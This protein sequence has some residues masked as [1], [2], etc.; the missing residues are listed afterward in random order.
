MLRDN[1]NQHYPIWGSYCPQVNF[2][3]DQ[4]SPILKIY[5]DGR[6][7]L[8]TYMI[9]LLLHQHR[10]RVV[11]SNRFYLD[12]F[13]SSIQGQLADVF[14]RPAAFESLLSLLPQLQSGNKALRLQD[15][16]P[17]IIDKSSNKIQLITALFNTSKPQ[18]YSN[19]VNQYTQ[20]LI[21]S[22]SKSYSTE[23]DVT[24]LPA[25]IKPIFSPNTQMGLW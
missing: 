22:I 16:I 15:I 25:L 6:S 3:A 4:V 10:K 13:L 2:P 20:Q 8:N 19:L 5:E 23:L 24:Q 14:S 18:F 7:R 17:P 9:F 21:D 12:S 11:E 1:I